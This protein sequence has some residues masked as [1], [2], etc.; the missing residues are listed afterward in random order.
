MKIS[1]MVAELER[2][3]DVHGDVDVMYR[4]DLGF[5][6]EPLSLHVVEAKAHYRNASLAVPRDVAVKYDSSAREAMKSVP[7]R[8]VVTVRSCNFPGMQ[9]EGL[10][11]G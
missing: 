7:S 9:K 10:A 2:L 3:K 5:A 6:A 11:N 8:T 1:E 4:G